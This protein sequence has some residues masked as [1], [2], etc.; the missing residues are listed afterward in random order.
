MALPVHRGLL[1]V[2]QYLALGDDDSL[3]WTEL[4][5]GNLV[6]SPRPRLRHMRTIKQL[7]AALDRQVPALLELVI[8]VDVDLQLAPSDQGGTVRN[9][10]MVVARAAE[11]E[12]AAREGT[13]LRANGVLLAV[14]IMSPGS[15]RTDTIIK[16]A[17]YADAGIP[18][19]WILELD[20][21]PSVTA[22]E[23]EAGGYR[24]AEPVSGV[25]TT[26]A[27]FPVR[28]ELDNLG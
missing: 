28:I 22:Y 8:E 16:R 1:T 13:I 21:R 20:P 9:P 7:S 23:L 11:A 6:M 27:P 19:Y 14:E 24:A 17:E 3:R 26:D 18:H 10:D 4:Q 25:F 12:R 2:E 15:R 5:E